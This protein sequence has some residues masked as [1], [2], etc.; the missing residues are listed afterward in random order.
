MVI[1]ATLVGIFNIPEA[2][3]RKRRKKHH[4]RKPRVRVVVVS[5]PCGST[6]ECP[7]GT[8]CI[9]GS[10]CEFAKACGS[11]K[12]ATCCQDDQLCCNDVC[13]EQS[14]SNCGSCSNTCQTFSVGIYQ[15]C[16]NGICINCTT[17]QNCGA[18]G[19][20][21]PS[22]CQCSLKPDNSFGCAAQGPTGVVECLP[23]V[24]CTSDA[25]CPP[26]QGCFGLG[27]GVCS[28]LCGETCP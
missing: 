14:N 22:T 18:C 16:C 11:G 1:G 27:G 28:A 26:G 8:T 19:S 6:A 24:L 20:V 4:R 9:N 21:C 12:T 25:E 10:C 5:P 15:C 23:Y 7:Q 2:E 13:I 3:A 17:P